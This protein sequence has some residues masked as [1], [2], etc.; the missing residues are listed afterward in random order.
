MI[1]LRCFIWRCAD[2]DLSGGF[3]E[4]HYTVR[5]SAEFTS[6]VVQLQKI[7]DKGFGYWL[8]RIVL[9]RN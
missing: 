9:L 2:L 5:T 6:V 8:Q 1:L 3:T 4:A 7:F